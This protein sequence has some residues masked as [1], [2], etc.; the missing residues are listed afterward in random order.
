MDWPSMASRTENMPR[1]NMV[2]ALIAPE[3]SRSATR[4]RNRPRSTEM[5]A[6]SEAFREGFRSESRMARSHC[7]SWRW[8]RSITARS[9]E[10]MRWAKPMAAM[11]T[12]LK[13]R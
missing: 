8:P 7:T 3:R 6:S 4:S 1:R 12:Y 13:S 11:F 9:T 2:S 5:K 10:S